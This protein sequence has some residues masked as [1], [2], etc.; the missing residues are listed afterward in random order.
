MWK[1]TCAS[2]LLLHLVHGAA[3]LSSVALRGHT[4]VSMAA[5]QS[6]GA[7]NS[8]AEPE[9]VSTSMRRP[10][11]QSSGEDPRKCDIQVGI[12]PL[13]DRHGHFGWSVRK[14]FGEYLH[15]SRVELTLYGPGTVRLWYSLGD[16]IYNHYLR[17]DGQRYSGKGSAT[18][19]IV[20]KS[21]VLWWLGSGVSHRTWGGW[22]LTLTELATA[23]PTPTGATDTP[24][25]WYAIQFAILMVL[26]LGCLFCGL[27]I[28]R[29]DGS[30]S[31]PRAPLAPGNE[32]PAPQGPPAPCNLELGTTTQLGTYASPGAPWAHR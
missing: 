32:K 26:P 23:T 14:P 13:T 8:T 1:A 15:T 10:D 12:S 31:A 16:D 21:E 30:A 28:A 18:F 19:D 11:C 7:P 5:V 4:A 20:G 17:I 3:E 24:W 9:G 25:I 29:R 2:I 27:C 22:D 6:K